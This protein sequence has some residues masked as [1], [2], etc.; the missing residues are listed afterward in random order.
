[1]ISL[2]SDFEALE[3]GPAEKAEASL[4]QGDKARALYTAR[5]QAGY[6]RQ[7]GEIHRVG[8]RGLDG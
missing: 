3:Q 1:V 7:P 5:Q 6:G 2:G 8:A 4:R